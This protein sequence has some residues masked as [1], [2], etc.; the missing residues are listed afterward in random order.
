[1]IDLPAPKWEQIASGNEPERFTVQPVGDAFVADLRLM[2]GPSA[3]GW[4]E[5]RYRQGAAHPA[6][7]GWI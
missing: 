5:Q 6:A 1:L 7:E 2:C 3:Q 4:A